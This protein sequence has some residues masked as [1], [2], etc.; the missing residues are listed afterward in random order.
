MPAGRLPGG[1][2]AGLPA[3]VCWPGRRGAR[4]RSRGLAGEGAPLPL[5]PPPPT[6]PPKPRRRRKAA[7]IFWSAVAESR[8]AGRRHRFGG[9]RSAVGGRFE[10]RT[11]AP[12]TG[13]PPHCACPASRNPVRL[14]PPSP[15]AASRCACRRTPHTRSALAVPLRIRALRVIRG[16]PWNSHLCVLGVLGV[17]PS[18][19]H[20]TSSFEHRT[21]N[22]EPTLWDDGDEARTGST[23]AGAGTTTTRRTSAGR[24]A[25]GTTPATATTTRVFVSRA[26][27]LAVPRPQRPP[28]RQGQRLALRSLG[29][30]GTVP[31]VASRVPRQT[32]NLFFRSMFKVRCSKFDVQSSKFDVRCSKFDVR[33]SK[34]DVRCSMVFP[35]LPIRAIRGSQSNIIPPLLPQP[36]LNLCVLCELGV[37]PSSQSA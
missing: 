24:T 3:R 2:N 7:G 22:M 32:C 12:A 13:N 21:L 17:R 36:V 29:G 23:G 16:S 14:R 31:S 18:D 20:R 34:F 25:T 9:V 27:P 19:K 35:T 1:G 15:K 4:Q 37:R 8:P 28:W 6:C 26:R 5:A 11:P 10:F 30:G 33:C